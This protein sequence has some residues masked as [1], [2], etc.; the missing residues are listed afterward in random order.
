MTKRVVVTGLGAITSLGTVEEYWQGLLAGRSGIR[1]IRSFDASAMKTKIAGEVDFNPTDYDIPAKHAR[2]MSRAAVMALCT[3]KMAMADADLTPEIIQNEGERSGVV[4]GTANAGFEILLQTV[5]DNRLKG[6]R[7]LPTALI[8]GLPNMPAHYISSYSGAAGPFHTVSATCA[9]GTQ[10]IGVALDQIRWGRADL[11]LTGGVDALVH[12]DVMMA[13]EAMT[14]LAGRHNDEPARASRPFDAGRDG[15]VMGEGCGVL[16]LESLEHAQAR[17]ARVYAE[18]LGY[19]TSSDAG[20]SAAPDSEGKGAANVMLWALQDAA[21]SPD[22]IS[23]INAHGTGTVVNDEME[24]KAIKRVFG[25]RAYRIPISSTKSMIGHCMGGSGALEAIACVKS[26]TEGVV[27]PT[28]NLETPDPACDLDYVP[29]HLRSLDLQGTL[30]NSFG[31]G[32]QN[33]CLV[34][35]VYKENGQPP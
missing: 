7:I 21:I 20:H 25:E 30:Y 17:S 9:S 23:Y 19:A 34:L 28:I 26:L 13:F 31:L 11:M 35:G 3:A 2:R 14:V 29:H 15:F 27:H 1:T 12:P 24:T 5:L 32:G 33:A 4:M 16:V 22:Q 8:N 6:V 10:A 18:V